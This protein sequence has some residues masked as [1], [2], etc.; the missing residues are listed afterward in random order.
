MGLDLVKFKNVARSTANKNVK[1]GPG[2]K[3]PATRVA[4]NNQLIVDASDR[5]KQSGLSEND[6]ELLIGVKKEALDF[7]TDSLI[8]KLPGASQAQID[9]LKERT[10]KGNQPGVNNKKIF[11]EITKLETSVPDFGIGETVGLGTVLRPEEQAEGV[12]TVLRSEDGGESLQLAN[13]LEQAFIDKDKS[14]QASASKRLTTKIEKSESIE[15]LNRIFEKLESSRSFQ[16][17]AFLKGRVNLRRRK[18]ISQGKGD[19]I[20]TG[21]PFFGNDNASRVA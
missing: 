14:K 4:V 21:Q 3:V 11:D 15:E 7:N 19:T 18:L 1:R 13:E 6:K 12:G 8:S 16:N 9:G 20:G 2:G 10:K 17:S 5:L